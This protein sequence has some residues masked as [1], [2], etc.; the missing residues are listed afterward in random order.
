MKPLLLTV[1]GEQV[2]ASVEPRTSLADFL[3]GGIGLT[4]THLGCEHGVCGACTILIDGKP[5][6]SCI[7]YA[8]Q[9]EG[10]DVRSI[11]GF[12]VDPVMEALRAEFNRQHALQCGFCT[13]GM[14]IMA[15]DI[16]NRLGDPGEAR[17]REELAGNLCRCTG[18]AG[19]VQAVRNVG[20]THGPAQTQQHAR[21]VPSMVASGASTPL[22]PAESPAAPVEGSTAPDLAN[23]N[24][25]AHEFVVDAPSAKV[26]AF[27]RDLPSVAACISGA[28][29]IGYD[30]Q[31]FRARIVV[32]F[33][34]MRASLEGAGTYGFD[35][36]AHTGILSGSGRDGLTGS[37]L[38]GSL[39][40]SIGDASSSSTRVKTVM[41][42]KLSGVLAQFSRG[43][44]AQQFVGRVM[45]QFA[46][47]ASNALAARG[48][49][50]T[51]AKPAARASASIRSWL[52]ILLRS[53][54]GR[55]R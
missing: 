13:P 32:K 8:V 31:T 39:A 20:A 54:L 14:L 30:D 10:C 28:D 11:E 55:G 37:L 23:A 29:L 9:M 48:I 27:F 3:R 24:V 51:G 46:E 45:T 2:E 42:F 17:V 36:S 52:S 26:W 7:T 19:I 34:P 15:R 35:E 16:V 6:R 43:S 18:Y 50:A 44:I 5:S 12:D 22:R 21:S 40:F 38:H 1:N 41:T 47:N 4:G 25:V 33:G 49:G 53:L